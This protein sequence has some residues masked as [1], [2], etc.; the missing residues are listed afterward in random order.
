MGLVTGL[1][2]AESNEVSV[3]TANR[4]QFPGHQYA[5][6]A[7][8]AVTSNLYQSNS[9]YITLTGVFD[10][11]G[12]ASCTDPLAVIQLLW[13]RKERWKMIKQLQYVGIRTLYVT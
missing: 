5:D 4:T 7:V 8:K 10:I 9:V 6:W 12:H 3:P 1:D 11:C 2:A 13:G